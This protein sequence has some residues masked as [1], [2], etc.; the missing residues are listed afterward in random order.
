MQKIRVG[1]LMGGK[2]RECEVSLNSGRTV[3]DHLDTACYEIIPLFQTTL[4]TLYILPWS[5][6]YRGK[7]V[8]F[9]HRLEKEAQKITW[10]CLKQYTDFIY[11]AMHGRYAEDGTLQG[12]L[13]LLKIPY[14]GSKVYAS[15]L[16]MDKI[17]QKK[18]LKAHG[19]QVPQG[20]ILKPYEKINA[21]ILD[22]IHNEKLTFPLII[23]PSKEGSSFGTTVVHDAEK[24]FDALHQ[25][26]YVNATPQAVLIE[27][28][29]SGMEFSC[30]VITDYKK[31]QF[32]PLPPTEIV[33]NKNV[34]FFDYDQKYMPGSSLQYT[35]ARCSDSLQKKIQTAAVKVMEIL[36]FKNL[37][38][39]DGFLTPAGNI[40]IIDPNSFFWCSTFKFFIQASCTNQHEPHTI[41]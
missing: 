31:Q 17:I 10:D 8:D 1:V 18:I 19:I 30:I 36:E 40:V 34:D 28:K 29:V 6:L 20:I 26:R 2:S 12:M 27:E 33:I 41:D 25:A 14:F 35:P 5:F 9:A 4:G 7:I 16:G 38:R 39:I 37:G 13:E 3:C 11:I 24:L 23:K 15:A 22:K 21:S 32:L